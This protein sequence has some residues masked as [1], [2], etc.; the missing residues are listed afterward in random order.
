MN[1]RTILRPL[2][3]KSLSFSHYL[4]L[5]KKYVGQNCYFNL[6]AKIFNL[7]N[8]HKWACSHER[9]IEKKR[10]H[11][12]TKNLSNH[13]QDVLYS[14]Y[15]LFKVEDKVQN[16]V[17][18]A[19]LKLKKQNINCILSELTGTSALWPCSESTFKVHFQGLTIFFK[20]IGDYESVLMLQDR[21]P[22]T[23]P[24]MKVE[25]LVMYICSGNIILFMWHYR[26]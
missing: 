15:V 25:S 24:S 2:S 19:L 6:S 10:N 26:F 17:N 21:C 11:G 22:S 8:E 23:C 5:C 14:K 7:R 3:W 13:S 9:I 16:G 1:H 4:L 20:L 18:I 12:E